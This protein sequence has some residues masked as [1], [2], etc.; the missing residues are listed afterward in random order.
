MEAMQE[1]GISPADLI[2]VATKN[3]ADAMRRGDDFGTLEPG[4]FAN[5]I[6]LDNDPAEDITNMR[7]ITHVMIKGSMKRVDEVQTH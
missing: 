4:K 7:S 6:L 2:V 1:A 3:G 5:L